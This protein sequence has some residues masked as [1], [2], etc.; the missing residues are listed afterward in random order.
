MTPYERLIDE[1]LEL[2]IVDSACQWKRDWYFA[3]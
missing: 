2:L 3:P 1:L